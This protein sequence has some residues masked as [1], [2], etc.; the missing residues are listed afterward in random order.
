MNIP[1][2]R[3]SATIPSMDDQT[4]EQLQQ[5][6]KD[7]LIDIIL[8]LRDQIVELKAIVQTQ[9]ERIKTLEDQLAKNSSNSGK[10]PSSDGLKKKPRSLREKGKRKTGGQAGHTGRTLKRVEE[11]DYEVHHAVS[12]CPECQANL[13]AVEV[14][15]IEKRQVFDIPDMHLEVTEHQG[16]V[17]CCPHCQAQVK[18]PFPEGVERAVQY[19]HRIQAQATYL[20]TYQLLPLA[21]TCELFGDFYGHQPSEAFILQAHEAVHAQLQAPLA[22]IHHQLVHAEV[23]HNDETGLRVEGKLNWLHV[24]STPTLT[25]YG[26]HPKRGQEALR[27]VGILP[28]FKGISVHDGLKA[29]FQFEQCQHALCNAHHLRELCFVLEQHKQTWAEDM[30]ALLRE[31]KREVEACEPSRSCLPRQRLDD[32]YRHY[33]VI[34]QCGLE[35]NPPPEMRPGQRGRQKQSAPKNLLDRLQK[36]KNPTLAFIADFRVPFD[37]NLAERDIRMMKVKQKISGTF[38]TRRGAD[39]F[40]DIRSYIS[41]VRKQ[42]HNVIEALS[43]ALMQHPFMPT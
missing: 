34:L 14:E 11:P 5:L 30:M 4:R 22:Q 25:Y 15:R 40:C 24:A 23:I 21:R 10:P 13:Q 35:A 33:D 36:H 38:R 19:G 32:Y 18:A 3:K 42:G 41:T 20:T 37:N 8:E 9:N 16:E 12:T 6:D 7:Q 2:A 26:V 39:V 29:Y 43:Q 28:Q 27:A 1:K 17:K 31:A